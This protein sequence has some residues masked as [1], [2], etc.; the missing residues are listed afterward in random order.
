MKRLINFLVNTSC[1]ILL[2]TM[3]TK[4]KAEVVKN[5][6]GPAKADV[7]IEQTLHQ[8][9][10]IHIDVGKAM[11]V[12]TNG[13]TRQTFYKQNINQE[14]TKSTGNV[15]ETKDV[16]QELHP[17]PGRNVVDDEKTDAILPSVQ[18][19]GPGTA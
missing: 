18:I 1:I 3:G 16:L 4:V 7:K 14:N 2:L 8:T 15:N 9:I 6:I 10:L 11:I 12:T 19:D 13:Q 5:N 17:D